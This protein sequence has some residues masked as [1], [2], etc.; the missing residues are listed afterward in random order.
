MTP[1]R[2]G[3][4]DRAAAQQAKLEAVHDQL[5]QQVAS[6]L[7]GADWKAWLTVAA[8]FHTYSWSNTLLIYSQH[9]DATRVAGYRQ[10]QRIGRQVT[11]GEQG[12]AILAPVFKRAPEPQ[13]DRPAQPHVPDRTQ[14]KTA[15]TGRPR[16]LVGFR[17][18][19]V[20]DIAQTSGDP[21][22]EQP[23]GGRLHGTAPAGLWDALAAQVTAAGFTLE[24]GDTAP[25]DGYTDFK[26]HTVRVGEGVEE[27][28]AVQVLAHE[29]A[30]VLLHDPSQRDEAAEPGDTRRCYGTGEVE[31]DSVAYLICT[32]AGL[33]TSATTFP[34]IAGWAT[35]VNSDQPV[36]VVEDTTRR[37]LTTAQHVIGQFPPELAGDID[38]IEPA[39]ATEFAPARRRP[40]ADLV[41]EDRALTL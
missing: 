10:W 6:L 19:Y 8:R 15:E 2:R 16:R 20:W 29:L 41:R 31:A 33:D 11:K 37:V 23:S 21:L 30:H 9:P 18:A 28:H 27:A 12:I 22:P 5:T 34:Y 40:N 35:G 14:N 25:A 4:A 24:R 1:A 32:V 3:F 13:D 17:V 39:R 36:K 7:D 26:T 38:P